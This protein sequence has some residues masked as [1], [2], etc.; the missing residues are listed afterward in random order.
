MLLY[1][2]WR[3]K[4]RDHPVGL[5]ADYLPE[6]PSD[7]PAGMAGTLVDESADIQD[8]LASILD[9]AR[10]GAVEIEEVQEKGF[11]GIGASSDFVYRRK[12]GFWGTVRP[13]EQTLLQK[14][15]KGSG[16]EVQLSE[17]KNK[18][19]TTIPTLRKQ[20]YEAVVQEGYF[21]K[22]PEATR[23]T[24]GCLGTA[25]L[26]AAVAIGFVLTGALAQYSSFVLCVPLAAAVTA[27]GLIIVARYMPRRTE[28]G[29]EEVARS[30]AFKR[31]LQNL[32]KYTKV[33]EAT[34]IFE[35]FLPY[36]VAFGLEQSFIR[37][38]QTVDAP[39]PTW[40]I[41]YG[42]PRPYYGGSGGDASM[43]GG[44]H[45]PGHAAPMPRESGDPRRHWKACR[46][47][48]DP[49]WPV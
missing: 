48:W 25:A 30:R 43:G 38:F 22:S 14:M 31:Y 35:R 49:R 44:G 34:G 40:W 1:L 42:F 33:E 13:Y 11:L 2:W 46:A 10:R 3:Q 26:V 9:L 28:K 39:P 15:F 27:V 24:Y 17:L 47:G 45:V 16:A 41:P 12:P 21:E 6:P 32:E 36:A 18:F 8:I 37:K 5:V 23:T 19:Y 20:L 29:S 4:G 7:M